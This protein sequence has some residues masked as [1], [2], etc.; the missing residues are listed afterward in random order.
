MISRTHFRLREERGIALIVTLVL[1]SLLILV[2]L[3]LVGLTR[4]ESSS[5]QNVKDNALARANAMTSLNIALGKLQEHAGPDA[6]VTAR[7]DLV[8]GVNG[9]SY[10]TGVW[11]TTAAITGTPT[12]WLVSGTEGAAAANEDSAILNPTVGTSLVD[13]DLGDDWV[14]MV[15]DSTIGG[16]SATAGIAANDTRRVRLLKQPIN[17][18]TSSLPGFSS[19]AGGNTRV[20][21][22]AYWIAD[23]GVK[24]SINAVEPDLTSLAYNNSGAGGD[25]WASPATGDEM[26][27]RLGQFGQPFQRLDRFFSG[28]DYA[29]A[30]IQLAL[31][32][33]TTLPQLGLVPNAGTA[34][35][36]RTNR[37]NSFH[38]FTPLSRGVLSRTDNVA[39]G[40]DRLRFDFSA[41]IAAPS[42]INS[43]LLARPSA[44]TG[45]AAT[46]DVA[47]G[48]VPSAN[49]SLAVTVSPVLSEAGIFIKFGQDGSG[50]LI[51]QYLLSAEFW[52]PYA[53]NLT[54]TAA[55]TLRVGVETLDDLT[56][57][58]IDTASV[59]HSITI[60]ANTVI[61]A[62]V[63]ANRIFSAG[64]VVQFESN[65]GVLD[66]PTSAASGPTDTILTSGL[67]LTLPV[68]SADLPAINVNRLRITLEISPAN[69]ANQWPVLQTFTLAARDAET[70]IVPGANYTFGYGYELNRDLLL[71]SDP[72]NANA[73]DPRS[74]TFDTALH[75]QP[76]DPTEHWDTIA[77]AATSTTIL[78]ADAP[79]LPSGGNPAVVLFDLPRQ[80][81]VSI[82]QLRHMLGDRPYELTRGGGASQP[83]DRDVFDK[84]FLST[85]PRNFGTWDFRTQA[86]PSRYL[87]VYIPPQAPGTEFNNAANQLASL[88]SVNSAR[89]QLIR[90]AFNINST[91]VAAWSSVLG[92]SL[93]G[94]VTQ[95]GAASVL[96]TGAFFRTPHNGQQLLNA[97]LVDTA[98]L[99][100]M[101]TQTAVGRILSNAEVS[102]L[103]TRIT[104][105][106]IANGQPF[107]SLAAFANS[108]VLANALAPLNAAL[109]AGNRST[110]GALTPGDI[111]SA[112]APFMSARSDTFKIRA[113]GD[114]VNPVTGEVTGR[115][116]CEALVQRTPDLADE[117]DAPVATVMRGNPATHPFGRKFQIISFRWLSPGDI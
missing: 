22:Y 95:E 46:Y 54:T 111:I 113:Y 4:V 33:V 18:P 31:S 58:V 32:R 97:S 108:P 66:D 25:D 115:A 29:D 19:G 116:W 103:A 90:G 36:I 110:A 12:A 67:S 96:V 41:D 68:T 64:S 23:E 45:L 78:A 93:G 100:D 13:D 50:N 73:K 74:G 88:Q 52:N 1:L 86:R 26:R 98:T 114:V 70:G 84:A 16:S 76:L 38:E 65:A 42:A 43:Y 83:L 59:S 92:A 56:Y 55:T 39:A 44:T 57:T 72:A 117:M 24:A 28:I 2:M 69:P 105:E 11:D 35:V 107:A 94:W 82:A 112:I 104:N 63:P 10:I 5:A 109:A 49:S 75:F 53:A 6:R 61:S 3:S 51:I 102:A 8:G 80:E 89:Y 47:V 14:F 37:Y 30:N 101:T 17:V 34:A 21:S 91:S 99:D 81:V 20:G 85:V 77:S 48:T 9:Q 60:P 87:D 27:L 106:L 62:Q 40:V 79:F 7:S 15:Y 71:W